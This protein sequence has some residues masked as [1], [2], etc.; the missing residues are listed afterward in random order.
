M[1]LG[2]ICS[3]NQKMGPLAFLSTQRLWVS[4][5]WAV[6]SWVPC[7]RGYYKAR[8]C[9]LDEHPVPLTSRTTSRQ[10]RSCCVQAPLSLRPFLPL[11]L[12]VLAP[13]VLSCLPKEGRG[14][15]F[16]DCLAPFHSCIVICYPRSKHMPACK[17][18]V[19][20]ELWLLF[21]IYTLPLFKK[22]TMT[23]NTHSNLTCTRF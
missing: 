19:N 11:H 5:V 21:K 2:G 13:A 16:P 14:L 23:I 12:C 22:E 17:D 8:D 20:V 4:R 15:H 9:L 6:F 3:Y 1:A 10:D 18:S 7:F